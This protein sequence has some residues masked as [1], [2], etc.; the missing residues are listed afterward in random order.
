[1]DW[2]GNWARVREVVE[3]V[4]GDTYWLRI[5]PGYRLTI[6]IDNR[7]A[8]WDCPERRRGSVFER[9]HG[10]LA[11]QA[12]VDWFAL[13][14][15]EPMW[16][17]SEPDPDDFGRWLGAVQT[18]TETLGDHLASLQLATPWPVRWRDVY[19]KR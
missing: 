9:E 8:G 15:G 13:H 12:A 6:L 5:D 19:D 14:D 17:Q 2:S 7:L 16:V 4:D 10:V 11:K 3:V 1:M 18:E